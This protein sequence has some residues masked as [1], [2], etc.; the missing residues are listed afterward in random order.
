M[1]RV[2][3]SLEP[4]F[5]SGAGP[6]PF[7]AHRPDARA[8]VR[9]RY[10]E[11]AR[12]VLAVESIHPEAAT[13]TGHDQ[14]QYLET[15]PAF[16]SGHYSTAELDRV[17]PGAARAS[18]GCG[19][20]TAEAL[21]SSGQIVLDVGCGGGIDSILA[22]AAVAP[23]GLVIG[24]DLAAE[25]VELARRNAA[26]VLIPNAAFVVGLMENLPLK[27]QAANLV[28][29]NSAI[30]LSTEKERTLAEL[31]RVLAPGGRL[32]VIDVVAD[33]SL[34]ESDR[35]ARMASTNAT[36]GLLS[37]SEYR[38]ALEAVGFRN[39]TLAPQHEVADRVTATLVAAERLLSVE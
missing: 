35:T 7:D 15:G 27:D 4:T 1:T 11:A 20:P 28:I 2:M 22:A 9:A 18:L 21:L 8:A 13:T 5:P 14:G 39:L 12:R 37:F 23:G 10:R 30:N 3:D 24:I 6:S 31:F 17:P 34:S 16:G 29:S 25:M 36:A 38:D 32:H 26:A 19:S 33:D